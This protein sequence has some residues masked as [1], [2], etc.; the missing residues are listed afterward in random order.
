VRATQRGAQLRSLFV[1]GDKKKRG[2]KKERMKK[3]KRN[4]CARTKQRATSAA[5]GS[6]REDREAGV[7]KN[8]DGKVIRDCRDRDENDPARNVEAEPGSAAKNAHVAR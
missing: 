2:K 7:N 3:K 6:E 1:G 4:N 5:G 8:R